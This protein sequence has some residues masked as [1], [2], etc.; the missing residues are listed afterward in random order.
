MQTL[1]E[2][3]AVLP[4]NSFYPSRPVA[5]DVSRVAYEAAKAADLALWGDFGEVPFPTF[6]QWRRQG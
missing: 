2:L 6:E 3:A 4:G 1:T 5:R